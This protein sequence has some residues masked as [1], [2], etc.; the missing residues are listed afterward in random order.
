MVYRPIQQYRG[1]ES[2]LP[3]LLPGELAVTTDS[4][5]LFFGASGNNEVAKAE[6]IKGFGDQIT[7]LTKNMDECKTSIGNQ[8]NSIN[9]EITTINNKIDGMGNGGSGGSANYQDDHFKAENSSGSISGN[10][11]RLSVS[12]SAGNSIM[13]DANGGEDGTKEGSITI[14]DKAN[15]NFG[16]TTASDCFQLAIHGSG[17]RASERFELTN[18]QTGV[19]LGIDNKGAYGFTTGESGNCYISSGSVLMRS[20]SASKYKDAI[21]YDVDLDYAKKLLS[22]N[23]ASW[24]DKAEDEALKYAAENKG[25]LPSSYKDVWPRKYVGVIAEDVEKAGLTELINY[26]APDKDGKRPVEGLMYDRIGALMIPMIK[27]LYEKIETLQTD[28][29]DLSKK[30]AEQDEKIK[31]L[32]D[33]K[34]APTVTSDSVTDNSVDLTWK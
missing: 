4:K 1:N 33:N 12:S 25:E 10:P 15:D 14:Y 5:K 19:I 18:P 9:G 13:L 29:E 24:H 34:V 2:D 3:E 8:I 21:K 28:N 6:D 20:V 26:G 23:P 7:D 30:L 22:V 27:D 31:A 17:K 11:P 32:Q 16:L